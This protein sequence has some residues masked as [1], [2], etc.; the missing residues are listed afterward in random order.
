MKKHLVDITPKA[1][2]DLKKLPRFIVIK[3]DKWKRTV[4]LIGLDET[5][6]IKGYHDEP[7]SGDRN[8]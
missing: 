6:K 7:L 5:R 1:I 2:K 8:G 3:L 4:E